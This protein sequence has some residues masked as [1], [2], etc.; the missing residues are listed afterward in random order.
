MR[1]ENSEIFYS[2]SENENYN[3]D[4]SAMKI[5]CNKLPVVKN[6]QNYL[7]ERYNKKPS[8]KYNFPEATSWRYG[9]F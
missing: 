1:S 3:F 4:K 6:K 9:W 8:E 2:L 5:D 7:A